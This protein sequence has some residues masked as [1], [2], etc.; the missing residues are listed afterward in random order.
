MKAITTTLELKNSNPDWFKSYAIGSIAKISG[1]YTTNGLPKYFN[2][3]TYNS[4]RR[5]DAYHKLSNAIH[6]AD[7]FY[8]IVTPSFDQ[9]TEKLGALYF[10]VDKFTYPIVV[11]TQEEQDAYTQQQEDNDNAST[12][13]G[14]RKSDGEIYLDRFNAYVYRQAVNNEITKAQAI[15]GLE[16]FYDALHPLKMGYFELS[17]NKLTALS[18]NAQLT[19]LKTKLITELQAYIDNE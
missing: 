8:D 17:V 14:Q 16:F 10:D 2:S 12:F 5:T 18:G 13:F 19:T 15:A 9:A 1:A 7:G 3:L 4:G 11:K 6:E